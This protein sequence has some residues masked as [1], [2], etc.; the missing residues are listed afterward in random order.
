MY[1]QAIA[2]YYKFP[3]A[4]L[5]SG[6]CFLREEGHSVTQ[7]WLSLTLDRIRAKRLVASFGPITGQRTSLEL[8]IRPAL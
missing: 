1:L 6:N 4:F 5:K 8:L 7:E 3:S 2:K